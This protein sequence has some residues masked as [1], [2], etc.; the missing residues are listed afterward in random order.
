MIEHL[1]R[2]YNLTLEERQA[3]KDL[4]IELLINVVGKKENL[5]THLQE[6]DLSSINKQ[7]KEFIEIIQEE[8]RRNAYLFNSA[9]SW[10]REN[11]ELLQGLMIV[12]AYGQ[13]G[14]MLEYR[15]EGNLLSGKV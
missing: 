6:I 15:G 10:T 13:A 4:D 12:P 3:A 14:K 1:K 2:L 5:I 9:L 11:I 8:N 7:E